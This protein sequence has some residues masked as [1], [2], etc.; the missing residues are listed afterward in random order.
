MDNAHEK[1]GP[2]NLGSANN[3]TLRKHRRT[4]HN[5]G[6]ARADSFHIDAKS[7]EARSERNKSHAYVH[8]QVG[9]H[10]LLHP[11]KQAARVRVLFRSFV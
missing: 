8:G 4:R 5:A 3:I 1:G 9:L 7:H 6:H 11:S 10:S 2:S